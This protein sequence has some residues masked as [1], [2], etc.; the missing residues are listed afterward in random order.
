MATTTNTQ[1][2]YTPTPA[3]LTN[4][5]A[6]VQ[7]TN[8]VIHLGTHGQTLNISFDWDGEECY[9]DDLT[10]EEEPDGTARHW[11]ERCGESFDSPDDAESHDDREPRFYVHVEHWGCN[12]S[13]HRKV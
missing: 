9:H 10:F 12:L 7:G 13:H 5:T 4:I 6:E 1:S 3:D 11:C 8:V 2:V